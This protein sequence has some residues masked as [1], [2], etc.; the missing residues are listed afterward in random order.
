MNKVLYINN[1]FRS[2][3]GPVSRNAMCAGRGRRPRNEAAM[4][5]SA[6][7]QRLSRIASTIIETA[8]R[9]GKAAKLRKSRRSTRVCAKAAIAAPI[10]R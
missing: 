1:N 9:M 8:G 3:M 6:S 7:E 5:A 2:N 4:N 10:T